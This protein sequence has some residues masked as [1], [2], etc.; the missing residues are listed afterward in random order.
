MLKF[1]IYP[2]FFISFMLLFFAKNF[3]EKAQISETTLECLSEEY[4]YFLLD[5]YGVF[6]GSSAIG[7]LPGAKV[8]MKELVSKGKK[9]GILSNSTQLA[10]KEKAKLLRHGV[11]EGVHYHF[12]VTSGQYAHEKIK[13]LDL[14]FTVKNY[15]YFLLQEDHPN[16]GSHAHLF[17]KTKFSRTFE[18]QDADFIYISIPHINGQDSIYPQDFFPLIEKFAKVNKPFLCANPDKFAPEGQSLRLVCRQGLIAQFLQDKGASVYFFGKPSEAVFKRA[19]QEFGDNI[20]PND[21]LMI[22]DTPETDILGANRQGLK[23]ALVTATGI[24]SKRSSEDQKVSVEGLKKPNYL[25]KRFGFDP[26]SF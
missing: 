10:E 5:A 15:K 14:P 24:Y 2:L 19:L 7:M 11:V 17:E 23:T 16:Y 18:I 21:I 1:R 4:D 22:G 13:A 26:K 25:I 12:L 6:W 20:N 3:A 8:T 9:V